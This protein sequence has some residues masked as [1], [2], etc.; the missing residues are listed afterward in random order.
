MTTVNATMGLLVPLFKFVNITT[1]PVGQYKIFF[2]FQSLLLNTPN[3]YI[4]INNSAPTMFSI[5]T[6]GNLQYGYAT[7][8]EYVTPVLIN[9]IQFNLYPWQDYTYTKTINTVVDVYG[10]PLINAVYNSSNINTTTIGIELVNYNQ[11]YR[12]HG[13]G[14]TSTT[15]YI[16]VH[17]AL[18][19]AV[20]DTNTQQS[21]IQSW[22][23]TDISFNYPS[24]ND[25]SILTG[26]AVYDSLL[27]QL[28]IAQFGTTYRTNNLC[29]SAIYPK[30]TNSLLIQLNIAQFGTPQYC[31]R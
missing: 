12:I 14:F 31:K 20:I 4:T 25:Y 6:T 16:V 5:D 7:I 28:N 15:G 13:Q 2:H 3:I 27:I 18:N 21:T 11:V 10:P 17:A 1:A 9:S 26:L 22:N 24:S 19:C 8:S 30:I 23:N 29:V